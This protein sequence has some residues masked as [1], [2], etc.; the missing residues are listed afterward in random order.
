MAE[1]G[2]TL[3]QLL[4]F[5]ERAVRGDRN[6]LVALFRTLQQLAH[7]PTAPPEERVLGEILSQVLMGE[8]NPD[9]SALPPGMRE[10][11]SALLARIRDER[12][13]N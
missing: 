13:S 12:S 6:L 5:V 3:E 11:V 7:H 10:E 4:L 1:P 8:T 9:L 2:V